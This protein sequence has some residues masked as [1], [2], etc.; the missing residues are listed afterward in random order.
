MGEAID[1]F[2]SMKKDGIEPDERTYETLLECYAESGKHLDD[3][4]ALLKEMKDSSIIPD[5]SHVWNLI[6]EGFSLAEGEEDQKKA[7]SIWKYLSGQQSYESLGMT[8]HME[9][10][11]VSPDE[12]TLCIALGICEVGRFE[13]EAHEVWNYGQENDQID[14]DSSVL[15]SYVECLATHGKKG[16]DRVVELIMLGVKGEKMPLRCVEPDE[17]KFEKRNGWDTH[18]AKLDGIEIIEIKE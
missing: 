4:L 17:E 13:K 5:P 8:L 1:V 10:L 12:G 9:A 15:T 7:L 3:M 2:A 14:L 16:A 11:S 6:L 18:A